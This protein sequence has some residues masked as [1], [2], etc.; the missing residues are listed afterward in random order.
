MPIEC[1]WGTAP[2]GLGPPAGGTGSP[3]QAAFGAYRVRVVD[4]G[5]LRPGPTSWGDGETCPGVGRGLWWARRGRQLPTARAR[6]LGG[7][8]VLPRWRWMPMEGLRGMAGTKTARTH[9]LGGQGV[10]PL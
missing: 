6:Q 4:G 9:E 1:L 8:G 5:P 7:R 2:C 3:A 10:P